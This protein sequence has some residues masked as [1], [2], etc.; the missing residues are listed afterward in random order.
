[1][2]A[3]VTGIDINK[4]VMH[5]VKSLAQRHADIIGKSAGAA[6]CTVDYNKVRIDLRLE[7]RLADGEEFPRMANTKLE[8]G[9]LAARKV[10]CKPRLTGGNPFPLKWHRP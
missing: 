1:M 3:T 7:H 4:R 5:E 8:S 2:L 10:L 6:V 9:T